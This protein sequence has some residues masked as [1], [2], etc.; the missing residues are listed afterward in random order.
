MDDIF[1]LQQELIKVQDEFKQA[2]LDEQDAEKHQDLIKAF[3]EKEDKLQKS[4]D[5]EIEKIS[6]VVSDDDIKDEQ[7]DSE[8]TNDNDPLVNTFIKLV[9]E[10]VSVEKIAKIFKDVELI[11]IGKEYGLEFTTKGTKEE[12]VKLIIEA[13]NK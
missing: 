10:N 4:V 9:R 8:N 6:E 3:S 12:K 13:I 7:E 5:K 1:E 11:E 2:I